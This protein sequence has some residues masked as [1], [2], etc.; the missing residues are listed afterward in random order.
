MFVLKNPRVFRP[1]SVNTFP[2]LIFAGIYPIAA[3]ATNNTAISVG[4]IA[5]I[6]PYFKDLNIQKQDILLLCIT[7]G[8]CR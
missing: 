4:N 3:T 2:M 8:G 7:S 6:K 1:G 5:S